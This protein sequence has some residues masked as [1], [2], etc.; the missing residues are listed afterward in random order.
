[1]AYL[2]Q[3]AHET[4]FTN[5]VTDTMTGDGSDTT[6]TLSTAPISVNN[7]IVFI[8]GVMQRPTTDF[9]VSGTTLTFAV[10]PHNSANVQAITGG[11]EHIGIPVAPITED[12]LEDGAITASKLE[13]GIQIPA[14]KITSLAASKIT[15]ALP[16]LDGSALT[17]MPPLGVGIDNVTVNP[18]PTTNP[19]GG[20]GTIHLN[21]T[22]GE[23]FVC[24]NAT[25][26]NNIWF[27]VGEGSGDI[28]NTAPTNPTS[29]NSF[30]DINESSS[31]TFQFSGATDP[32]AAG[33]VTHYIVD[34]F[35]NGVLSVSVAEVAAGSSHTFNTGAVGSDTAVTFR[36][37]AK[38]NVGAYSS[39]VTV[40]MN[41]TDLVYIA[42]TG[43]SISTSG[44]YK[45]HAFTGN[46]TFTVTAVPASGNTAID[47]LVVAG[48]GGGGWGA[49]YIASGGGGSTGTTGNDRY[50]VFTGNG[51]LSVTQLGTVPTISFIC[52]GGGGSG[53]GN[54]GGGAGAGGMINTTA[55]LSSTG[56]YSITVGAGASGGSWGQ[57]SN[58]SNSSISGPSFSQTAT[59][60]GGGGTRYGHGLSG[61][62]G[63]GAGGTG[64]TTTGGS[65][66]GGQ[67]HNGGN[68]SP[69]R[70]RAGGGGGKSGAGTSCT[71][72]ALYPPHGGNG[73]LSSLDGS[74]YYYAGGGGGAFHQSHPSGNGGLGGAGGGGKWSGYGGT[75]QGGAQGRNTGTGGAQHGGYAGAN[76]GSGGGG[77]GWNYGGSYGGGGGSGIVIIRY[78]YQ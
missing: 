12:Q 14:S 63:G 62:S 8:D 65:G 51:T 28:T 40:S 37:R 53:A 41:V 72:T 66:V 29:T 16:A 44:D 64:T 54:L 25:A 45:Y 23:M 1:M 10:A 71:S 24:T 68:A 13:S 59:G 42:A 6:L 50:H 76:T 70:Q 69:H 47:M 17:N 39:G 67:G 20:V 74:S 46:S 27:N 61:G 77:G 33:S 58:G 48:G 30:P 26:D 75:S 36:V 43:G 15:G 35:S 34:N 49:T 57:G 18:S 21:K 52:V 5:R 22:T 3:T 4:E 55:T 56:N 32:D 11:G 60:G 73:Q 78:T 2:G 31:A 9:T 38:D 7:V 19:S